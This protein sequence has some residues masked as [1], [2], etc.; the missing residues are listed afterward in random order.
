MGC[1]RFD[2]VKTQFMS[3]FSFF[4]M[5]RCTYR[6]SHLREQMFFFCVTLSA[7]PLGKWADVIK[8]HVW[9]GV[10]TSEVLRAEKFSIFG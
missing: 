7:N 6:E 10:H 4:E 2:S 3:A 5:S 8:L 1:M 9:Q